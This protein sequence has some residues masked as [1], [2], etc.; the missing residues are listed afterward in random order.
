MLDA[1][2]IILQVAAFNAIILGILSTIVYY[3]DKKGTKDV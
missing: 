1:I 2:W 3:I